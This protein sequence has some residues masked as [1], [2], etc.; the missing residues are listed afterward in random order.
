MNVIRLINKT[1]GF[2]TVEFNDTNIVS[3][4]NLKE[5]VVA[6]DGTVDAAT[7]ENK[8][9]YSTTAG[10][11]K[12]ADL[13]AD[14]K[15]VVLTLDAGVV[16]TNQ[17]A[18]KVSVS[19]VKAGDKV[20]SA[21][22]FSFTPLDNTLPE[23]AQV[24]TLGNKAV[25]VIM[26]EPVKNVKPGNFQLDGKSFYG[27][28]SVGGSERELILKPY[29]A[30]SLTTGEHKLT[31]SLVEDYYNLKSLSKEFTFN[32]V[33]DKEGPTVTEAKATLE[34]ATLTFNEDLDADTVKA[35]DVYWLS[36]TTKKYAT[37]L[38]KLAGNKY[39]FEFGVND[40][41]P[42]YETTLYIDS[43][44]D[45][46]G[47]VNA[48]KDVKIT[49]VVDQAR[50]EVTDVKTN[51][52]KKSVTVKFSKPVTVTASNFVITDNTGKNIA[53]KTASIDS[54]GKV[55]TVELYNV[56][57]ENNAHTIKVFG[58]Q[59]TTTLK[60]TMLDYTTTF[61]LDDKTG[62]T[63]AQTGV[64]ANSAER[65]V[66]L[67]FN[68]KMDLASIS[69]PASYLIN[70]KG[71]LRSLPADTEIRPVQDGKGVLFIFPEKIGT[72]AV[73]F[74]TAAGAAGTL[75]A[76][77][78]NGVKDV[79]G[80]I[81]QGY[82]FSA[83]LVLAVADAT[84]AAYS[85]SVAKPAVFTDGKTLK[86]RFNQPIGTAA[87]SDFVL[88][89]G[90]IESVST[91]GT[92]LVTI[93]LASDVGTKAAA[94]SLKV[95]TGNTI[96]TVTGNGVTST[97]PGQFVGIEDQVNP[98]VQLATNV[99]TLAS[100]VNGGGDVVIEL[101][102][103]ETLD[104]TNETSF[105]VDLIVTKLS[106]NGT[107]GVLRA[108]TDYTTAVKAN[109]GSGASLV[110][111]DHIIEVTIKNAVA[112]GND[113]AYSVQV[114][115]AR[116]IEDTNANTADDSSV[117]TT[118]ATTDL[119]KPV[120]TVTSTTVKAGTNVNVTSDEAGVAYL[121]LDSANITT[122]AGADGEVL[123]GR[124]TKVA[125]NANT[126]TALS[127]TALADGTY[128]VITVDAAGN[129]S[130]E[131]TG[132]V[133]IDSTAPTATVTSGNATGLVLTFNE[134]LYVGGTAVASGDVKS[135]FT[136]ANLSVGGSTAIEITSATY[137]AATNAVTFVISGAEATDT[138]TVSPTVT[139]AAGNAVDLSKDVA[140]L[141][142]GPGWTLN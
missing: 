79:A 24:V 73:T 86:V 70:F 51:S 68:E 132:V 35:G 118:G 92:N 76:L 90:T 87:A 113:T 103:S 93:K 125:V 82:S 114:K 140:T 25:K 136:A 78:V 3:A 117:Y 30:S 128:K 75:T 32:V 16:M 123:A 95:A 77:Q 18:Y 41:L 34:T 138:I 101:P 23:V 46:S 99:N 115:N 43:V 13:S 111:N 61:N 129:V 130:A 14:G 88:T 124:A 27:S 19:K 56:I 49:A 26:T 121:V 28:V 67:T 48:T 20:V 39:A 102:M 91:D 142:A 106:A 11:V 89:G 5:V 116:Y 137:N 104:A 50:P 74:K 127:T 85:T 62:P 109:T 59:D 65:T 45:Y 36:G 96:K 141:G 84:V 80:N 42:A 38:T 71:S 120:A 55:A 31:V 1:K 126:S 10:A 133:T 122:V 15:T 21:T 97:A 58:V 131:S 29:D 81:L 6:F 60:N 22:D 57:A 54:T 2:I 8:E 44:S 98:K 108:G 17:K 4:T 53:I 63:L 12:S 135:L 69:N 107:T 7:A 83:D 9:N 37:G 52:D 64:S 105:G 33:E 139:D 134:A 112:G 72:D 119:R 94:L 110:V 40:R 47:N 66:I 100:S